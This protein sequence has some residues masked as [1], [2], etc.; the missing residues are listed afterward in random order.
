MTDE[1]D[2]FLAP[3]RDL[4]SG[5]SKIADLVEE[6]AAE[7]AGPIMS[8]Q[9]I[10]DLD[11]LPSSELDRV[12]RFLVEGPDA[13]SG[14]RIAVIRPDVDPARQVFRARLGGSYEVFFRFLSWSERKR[15]GRSAREEPNST[16]ILV[17]SIHRVGKGKER[18]EAAPIVLEIDAGPDIDIRELQ[19]VTEQLRQ[20]LLSH[21]VPAERP[22]KKDME[23]AAMT[24]AAGALGAAAVVATPL[25]G[26]AVSALA[27]SLVEWLRR[28]RTPT[29]VKIHVG[30]Q[31]LEVRGDAESL[32]E[33]QVL[34]EDWLRHRL[35]R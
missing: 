27:A 15:L 17:L 6:A 20:E 5:A 33:K 28:R 3:G 10:D 32:Q 25:A 16:D 19:K 9:A 18:S 22:R 12:R 29:S 24:A 11:Q 26:A 30:D 1:Y 8:P 23:L 13:E 31:V 34:V 14:A 35:P 4:L 2:R 21:D 7:L